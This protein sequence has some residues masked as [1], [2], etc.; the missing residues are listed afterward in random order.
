MLAG[1]TLHDRILPNTAPDRPT[2]VQYTC[3]MLARVLGMWQQPGIYDIVRRG[4][5]LL[6]EPCSRLTKEAAI[7]VCQGGS[8]AAVHINGA[9][10]RWTE[11]R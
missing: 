7:M 9:M 3:T 4:C 11:P 2:A 1:Q 8:Y 6:E 5:T 10:R